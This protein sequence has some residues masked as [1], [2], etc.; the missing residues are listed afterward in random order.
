VLKK[1]FEP[2]REEVTGDWRRLHSEELH[3]L[4]STSSIIWV[5]TSHHIRRDGW[6]MWHVWGSREMH[7]VLV[8]KCEG[9]RTLARRSHRW[10]HILK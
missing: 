9:K 3:D 6:G 7:M 2:K 10:E 4:H 5:I 8:V 1:L